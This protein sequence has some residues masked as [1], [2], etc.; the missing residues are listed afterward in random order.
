MKERCIGW[1]TT[2]DTRPTVVDPPLALPGL[3]ARGCDRGCG[4][5]LLPLLQKLKLTP[6]ATPLKVM[7]WIG[8]PDF[9]S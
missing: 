3:K 1:T 5:A 9:K 4:S 6:A 2:A 8:S 7:D